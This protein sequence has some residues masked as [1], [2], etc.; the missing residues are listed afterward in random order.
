[1]KSQRKKESPLFQKEKSNDNSENTK[2]KNTKKQFGRHTFIDN[3]MLKKRFLAKQIA[4]LLLEFEEEESDSIESIEI[5]RVN[6]K[7]YAAKTTMWDM[8][9]KYEGKDDR[10]PLQDQRDGFYE[11][12]MADSDCAEG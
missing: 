1:M 5:R 3:L 8:H 7:G 10:E 4:D 11:E 9:L 12:G 2:S 6:T